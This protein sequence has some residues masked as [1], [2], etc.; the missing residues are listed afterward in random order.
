MAAT[1]NP[2]VW[3][4]YR[5]V[6]D[7]EG[8][9][10]V[11]EYYDEWSQS[12]YLAD[13]LKTQTA[14]V[15]DGHWSAA[16]PGPEITISA[17]AF[18]LSAWDH[19][20][21]GQL[22]GAAVIDGELFFLRYLYAKELSDILKTG[23]KKDRNDSQITQMSFRL[24]NAGEDFFLGPASLFAPGARITAAVCM[25]NSAPYKIGEAYLDEFDFDRN[26]A[27]VSMSGRNNI[28]FRLNA[29]TFDENTTFTGNGKQVVEWI[30]GLA[31]ITKYHV[32]ASDASN[33]WVFEPEDTYLKGLEK[34]FE[35]FVGWSMIELPDGTVCVGYDYDLV[36]WQ[37]NNVYQFHG[38][39]EVFRRKT[40]KNA[41]AAFSKVRV[42]GKAAD[43]TELTP[44]QLDVP[45]FSHWSL[46]AHKTK[47]VKA[48]DGLTQAE[49]QAYAEQ[50][51]DELQYIGA[52]ETFD[53]PMRPW[54]LV[55]DIASVTYDGVESEDLGLINSITHT[56]GATGF[57]TSFTIDSGGSATA[58]TRAGTAYTT[59]SAAVNGYN[60]RQDLADLI[61][62]LGGGK[63][64]KDGA[65]G[66]PGPVGPAGPQG[67][68][69]PQGP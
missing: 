25:G 69:G 20:I 5:A 67:P 2:L 65:A 68:Q 3:D 11:T 8:L 16:E 55:G 52:G 38:G 51:R 53:G 27:D 29:Q 10:T 61:G 44:V 66:A 59:R 17:D 14:V 49:L 18:T 30:F 43:G 64:G 1:S 42:T 19:P 47:H 32:G 63:T 62:V 31:G 22:Y 26:A 45:N 24:A 50:L 48:A 36:R 12:L 23:S 21:N 58:Q 41:D 6:P 13:G 54:I 7:A 9:G 4:F 56:F 46:G 60:R 37:V 33:E 40:K 15:E 57:F 34:I 28:G 35:V 39:S